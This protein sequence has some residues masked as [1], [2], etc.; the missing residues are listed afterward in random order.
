MDGAKCGQRQ[1]R[2]QMMPQTGPD[3]NK[4]KH[5]L[6]GFKPNKVT[7]RHLLAQLGLTEP[8]VVGSLVE[9]A[10]L[11]PKWSKTRRPSE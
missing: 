5:F 6:Q 11:E 2:C 7:I 8:K 9:P 10:S 3:M 1:C 4:A